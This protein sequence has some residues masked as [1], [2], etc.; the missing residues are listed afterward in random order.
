MNKIFKKLFEENIERGFSESE[1]I[2]G[3]DKIGFSLPFFIRD[4]Y[5]NHAKNTVI[6]CINYFEHPKTF[7]WLESE[8]LGFYGE[9]QGICFWAINKK[10]FAKKDTK[11]YVNFEGSGYIKE[12]NTFNDFLMIRALDYVHLLFPYR[13]IIKNFEESMES[14]LYE[15]YGEPK[16]DVKIDGYYHRRIFWTSTDCIVCIHDSEHFGTSL[17]INSKQNGNIEEFKNKFT[18]EEWILELDR[19]SERTKCKSLLDKY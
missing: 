12:A 10:D 14:Y 13:L 7:T 9:N 2:V 5:L 6:N 16:S 17:L 11:V 8:W 15:R 4:F 1:V 19:T 3:E 18:A